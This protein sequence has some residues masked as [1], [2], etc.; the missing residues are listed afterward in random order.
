MEATGIPGEFRVLDSCMWELNGFIDG[1][2]IS[3]GRGTAV[4]QTMSSE[5][6][7]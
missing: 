4:N 1:E 6:I 5:W 2:H 7:D 3:L